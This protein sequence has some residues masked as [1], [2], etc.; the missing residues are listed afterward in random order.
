MCDAA[1]LIERAISVCIQVGANAFGVGLYNLAKR[2][3][4]NDYQASTI[5]LLRGDPFASA[6]FA[7]R[8]DRSSLPADVGGEAR[9][10]SDGH[11]C[12]GVVL[13]GPSDEAAVWASYAADDTT[14][15]CRIIT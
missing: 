5:L 4:L 6:E 11:C 8:F 7:E 15:G 2:L 1:Q 10:G 12:V 14:K 3:F 9:D 13:P